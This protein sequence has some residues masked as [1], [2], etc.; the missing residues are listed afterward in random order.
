MSENL[1]KR[2]V[3]FF[4]TKLQNGKN[5]PVLALFIPD[6]YD[7]GTVVTDVFDPNFTKIDNW[8][9]TINEKLETTTT[10]QEM[11][12]LVDKYKAKEE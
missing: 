4:A 11:T 3:A 6:T 5:T 1:T 2:E 12:A 8:A 10:P 7:H 9:K